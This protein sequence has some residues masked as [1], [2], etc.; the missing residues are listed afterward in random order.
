MTPTRHSTALAGWRVLVPRGGSY[1]ENVAA[2]LRGFGA[3]AVVA[4]MVNFAMP[5]D[6]EPLDRALER[7]ESGEY[8]WFIV[9]SGTTVDVLNSHSIQVPES[10]RIACVGETTA[11]ALSLGGYRVDFQPTLDDSLRGLIRE[12]P[13]DARSGRVL[14]P[15]PELSEPNLLTGLSEIGLD[16]DFVV[17]YRTVGV[18][19]SE[20]VALDVA[21]GR[22]G[23][24]LVSSG[25]VA[26]QVQEQLGPLPESTVVAC[27]GPRTA[28]DA[29][30]AGLRVDVIAENRDANLLVQSLAEHVL[31]LRS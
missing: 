22:I 13:D 17:A 24:I 29:R 21:S 19:I 27:I 2:T 6:H 1:G 30:A 7:L 31:T 4:P 3:T 28:F 16:V 10:T 18:Q 14:A 12:W 5:E 20:R 26:R 8:D 23:A 25:S 11:A 9:A 15:Q